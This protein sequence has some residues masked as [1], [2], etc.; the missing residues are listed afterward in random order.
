MRTPDP[1]RSEAERIRKQIL[2]ERAR[3]QERAARAKLEADARGGR[4]PARPLRRRPRPP[5]SAT[6]VVPTRRQP[7]PTPVVWTCSTCKAEVDKLYPVTPDVL[8]KIRRWANM[9]WLDVTSFCVDC[10]EA[11]L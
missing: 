9:P 8:E 6:S 3:L 2:T 1:G 11:V 7:P 4:V 5:S 10:A